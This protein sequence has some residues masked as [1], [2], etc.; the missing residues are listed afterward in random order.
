MHPSAAQR[1]VQRRGDGTP[2]ARS[3][4]AEHGLLAGSRN[5]L[6]QLVGDAH[7]VLL[8]LLLI[9]RSGA[10]RS[11]RPNSRSRRRS[12]CSSASVATERD[13]A[14]KSERLMW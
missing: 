1:A 12:I 7:H 10:Q 13:N 8:G 9:D 11:L 5:S 4:S 6:A 3:G 2:N 14:P